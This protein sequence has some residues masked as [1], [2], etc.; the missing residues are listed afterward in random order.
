MVCRLA[1]PCGRGLMQ[2][3]RSKSMCSVAALPSSERAQCTDSTAVTR[4]D[5]VAAAAAGTAECPLCCADRVSVCRVYLPIDLLSRHR[6]RRHVVAPRRV[7][8]VV[9]QYFMSTPASRMYM[10][11]VLG[12]SDQRRFDFDRENCGLYAAFSNVR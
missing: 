5:A 10:Y 3:L 7:R 11:T 4:S 9:V 6:R 12:G 2:R 8:S 1:S